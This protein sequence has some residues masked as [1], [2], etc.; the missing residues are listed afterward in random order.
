M[1]S[2]IFWNT[3]VYICASTYMSL[4][5]GGQ[6]EWQGWSRV[7]KSLCYAPKNRTFSQCPTLCRLIHQQFLQWEDSGLLGQQK[8]SLWHHQ[9]HRGRHSAHSHLESKAGES[10]N[11]C[12]GSDRKY[13]RLCEP[14]I[15]VL[16]TQLQVHK[17]P[18]TTCQCWKSMAMLDSS[19]LPPTL[20]GHLLSLLRGPLSFS[21][22]ENTI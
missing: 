16:C 19:Q 1:I 20:P 15:S 10:E 2:W 3:N 7:W 9:D 18:Q 8:G 13:S 6:A 11:L 22:S 4:C 12:E 21:H 5:G 14:F 17:Q